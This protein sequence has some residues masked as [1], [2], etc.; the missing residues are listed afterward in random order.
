DPVKI[1]ADLYAETH[2]FELFDK[3]FKQPTRQHMIGIK[4]PVIVRARI[5][6]R[7]KAFEIYDA[8]T[9]FG[10]SQ[11]LAKLVSIAF[12]NGDTTL[13]VDT[14]TTVEL[15]DI[16]PLVTI[17]ISGH[18]RADAKMTMNDGDP[19]LLGGIKIDDFVMGGFPVG[20]IEQAKAKFRLLYLEL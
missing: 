18:A 7:P 3:G 10:H 17:P 19:T 11:M 2:E 4:S 16:S 8:K 1:D 5:G 20:N 9:E 15:A 6:V 13:D 12:E 14:L